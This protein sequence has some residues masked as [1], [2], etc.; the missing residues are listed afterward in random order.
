MGKVVIL[1]IDG[2]TFT[3]LDPLLR[4]NRLPNLARLAG[5]GVCGALRSTLHPLTPAA[6]TSAV[7][8]VN[9]G[10]H[11]IFD[12]R[13]R[14]AGSYALD[15]V[16]ARQRDAEPIWTTLSRQGR[17]VGVFNVPM[18]YPPDPVNGFMVSGMDTPGLPS[19]FVYPPSLRAALLSAVP[20]Y[21][22][23]LDEATTDVD[24][25][26]TRVQALADAQNDALT[27]LT[28]RFLDLDFLMAV[29]VA[30]DRLYHAFWQCLD[31]AHP[32][33]A[34]A[35]G[36]SV[37]AVHE[38]VL[39]EMD[40]MLGR[41]WAWAGDDATMIVMSD[42]G[43]GALEKDVSINRFLSDAGYLVFR[44]AAEETALAD[45]V[46]WPRT[47][48]YAFGFFGNINLNLRGREPLGCVEQGRP[49]EDLKND[50][51]ARLTDLRDPESGE[52]M[53]SAIYR[54]EDVYSGP[55][56]GDAPDLLVVMRDYAYMTRDGYEGM[57]SGLVAPPMSLTTGRL[58]HTGNHRLDGVLMMAGPGVRA[59]DTITAATLNDIAPTALYAL[60]LPTPAVMDG[61]VLRQAFT[62]ETLR[63]RPPRR[64]VSPLPAPQSHSQRQIAALATRV[65]ELETAVRAQEDRQSAAADYALRLE[66]A[67]QGKDTHIAHLE[68]ALSAH[69]QRRATYER[70]LLFRADQRWQRIVSWFRSLRDVGTGKRRR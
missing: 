64:I 69:E 30:T 56:L 32:A 38:R 45:A 25:Y 58:A 68:E 44:A 31:A 50:L 53:V 17:R 3:L 59:G 10:K 9:P 65:H 22:I 52:R 41:L 34:T 47:R 8:G 57:Q 55:H 23:D 26:L 62:N 36:A 20:N 11:G 39:G 61:H 21:Q 18:T 28:E 42:H 2:A 60:G 46:D 13:R 16:N 33:Y 51:I 6:W 15:L 14:R 4:D 1:G 48:A 49:A 63:Q 7:T 67:V 37:R 35:R 24:A 70:S 54:R 12:F 29:L 66:Q 40:K 27:A 19:A 43:F 5:A